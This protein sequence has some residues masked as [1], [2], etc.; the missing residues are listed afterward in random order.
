MRIRLRN[1]TSET[2]SFI[3]AEVAAFEKNCNLFSGWICSEQ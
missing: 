1:L 3:E 2:L